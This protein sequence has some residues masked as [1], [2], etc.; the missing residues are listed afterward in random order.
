MSRIFLFTTLIISFALGQS[1]KKEYNKNYAL[2]RDSKIVILGEI[3]VIIENWDKK[4]AYIHATLDLDQKS[5]LSFESSGEHDILIEQDEKIITIK[6]VKPRAKFSII[7]FC[8]DRSHIVINMPSW[9]DIEVDIDDAAFL[10][11]SLTGKVKIKGDDGSIVINNLN[12]QKAKIEFD[13]GSFN[14]S[15]VSGIL[16]LSFNDGNAQ[17]SNSGCE[18]IICHFDDGDL[19][20]NLT[21]ISM[22]TNIEFNDGSATVGF[23]SEEL[24][25]ISADYNDGRVRNRTDLSEQYESKSS[26][27]FGDKEAPNRVKAWFDDGTFTIS[28]HFSD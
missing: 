3:D 22:N 1:I 28:S 19:R 8:R 7:N 15:S 5:V 14:A 11:E 21:K 4:E 24:F 13:D 17:I 27:S 12:S 16:I 26:V 18:K 23:Q 20:I 25:Y 6:R 10:A 2:E 9:L